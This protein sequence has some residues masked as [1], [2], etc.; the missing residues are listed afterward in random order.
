[1]MYKK[2][3]PPEYQYELKNELER[4][5]IARESFKYILT[6]RHFKL[7]DSVLL[8]SKIG[9]GDSSNFKKD[10]T[11]EH[12]VDEYLKIIFRLW[13]E[14]LDT[15]LNLTPEWI[16]NPTLKENVRLHPDFKDKAKAE[17]LEIISRKPSCEKRAMRVVHGDLCPLN[18]IFD[19]CGH[20]VGLIDLGDLHIGDSM[21]D[22]AV[23]SWTIRGNFGKK[24]EKLFLKKLGIDILDKTVEYYRLI[25]DLSLPSYKNWNWIKE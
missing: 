19:S 13:R 3:R 5:K 21:L 11:P 10:F 2:I 4:L 22:V 17:L 24:Y 8:T 15:N 7:K 18:I 16:K 12:F 20:A 9:A 23:L 1:M 6:P 14:K 25:Y